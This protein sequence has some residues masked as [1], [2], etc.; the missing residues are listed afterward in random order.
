[1]N[2]QEYIQS[3]L[4]AKNVTYFVKGNTIV[5]VKS[6]QVLILKF[7][8]EFKHIEKVYKR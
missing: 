4:N 1:M 6:N 8:N 5:V 3:K 2:T 7:D